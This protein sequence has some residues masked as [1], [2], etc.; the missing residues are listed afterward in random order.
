MRGFVR[1]R[2]QIGQL[3]ILAALVPY[4]SCAAELRGRRV[5]HW[6]DSTS[7]IAALAKGYSAPDSARLVHAFHATAGGGARVR[8][9]LRVRTLGG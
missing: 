2:Q 1:R 8:V 3:G 9:L 6:V 7:A 4:L 5:L